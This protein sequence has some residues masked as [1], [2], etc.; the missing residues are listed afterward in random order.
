M[1]NLI[2][3]ANVQEGVSY[4]YVGVDALKEALLTKANL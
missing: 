3:V 1:V 2:K 4:L